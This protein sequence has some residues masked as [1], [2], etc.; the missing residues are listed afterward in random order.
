[1]EWICVFCGSATGNLPVFA[2]NARLLA[3]A[4][5]A[6]NL[7]L[8]FGGGN[9]GLMG[10]LA[11]TI[12][13]AGG[14]AVGVI[15][16]GLVD[17]ELAHSNLTRLHVVDT[18]HQRKALMAKLADGF[19]AMPGGFG[20]ADEFFDILTWAQLGLHSKPIGLLNVAGYFDPLLAWMERALE[21]GFLRSKDRKLIQIAK[22]ADVLLDLL[23]ELDP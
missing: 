19:I 22:N 4:M 7:H 21:F 12:L 6:R 17:K 8:V 20:T 16:Q 2:D 9:I 18:L 14:E 15:S 23:M 11:D 3:R 5:A 10:I 1:M 13:Q